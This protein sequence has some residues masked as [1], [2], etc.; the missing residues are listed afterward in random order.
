ML[1]VEN[2][3]GKYHIVRFFSSGRSRQWVKAFVSE[4]FAVAWCSNE[5]T[6]K[7][8]KWFDGFTTIEPNKGRVK[9]AGYEFNK[10]SDLDYL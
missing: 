10:I 7:A 1:D 2:K 9:Y 8:G 5:K 6:R 3:G 4:E